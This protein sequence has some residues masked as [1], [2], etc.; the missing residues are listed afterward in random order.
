MPDL[1]AKDIIDVQITV[2]DLDGRAEALL[3]EAGFV[4][5]EWT[6]DHRPPGAD[7]PDVELAKRAFT[8]SPGERRTNIHVRVAGRF[9]QRYALLCRD[10]LRAHPGAAHAYAEVKRALADLVGDDIDAYYA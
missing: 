8:E 3:T 7:L 10:Y 2:A 5:Q 9:N 1:A 4:L 6:A